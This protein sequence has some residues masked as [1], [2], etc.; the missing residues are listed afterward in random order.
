VPP[1]ESDNSHADRVCISQILKG[2]NL[3]CIAAICNRGA[4]RHRGPCKQ[5][6]FACAVHGVRSSTLFRRVAP[7]QGA[8]VVSTA[9]HGGAAAVKVHNV[10]REG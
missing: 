2:F 3:L 1:Q 9:I 8:D 5:T 4:D 6:Q 10:L 7:G